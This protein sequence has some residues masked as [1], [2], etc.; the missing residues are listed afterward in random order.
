M[1]DF[2]DYFPCQTRQKWTCYFQVEQFFK[3]IKLN[4]LIMLIIFIMLIM[5]IMLIMWIMWIMWI[6]R[7]KPIVLA[8]VS[9]LG[10]KGELLEE[11]RD[12]TLLH[13]QP[14]SL[15]LRSLCVYSILIIVNKYE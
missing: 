12:R 7:I 8:N 13:C 6:M 10:P 2:M 4:M 15:M 11:E 9:P 5:L 3:L 1:S 14:C